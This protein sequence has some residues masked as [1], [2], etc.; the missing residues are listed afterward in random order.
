M[1]LDFTQTSLHLSNVIAAKGIKWNATRCKT[2]AVS[3]QYRPLC[4]SKNFGNML[5]YG[6]SSSF[7]PLVD[8]ENI[9][10]KQFALNNTWKM[11]RDEASSSDTN[12]RS[13]TPE[14]IL[15][16][17]IP[18]KWEIAT[19]FV[20][21]NGTRIFSIRPLLNR[22]IVKYNDEE[23]LWASIFLE[24]F[25]NLSF[26]LIFPHKS[27]SVVFESFLRECAC[28]MTPNS[29]LSRIPQV[30]RNRSMSFGRWLYCLIEAPIS[31]S[32]GF[33]RNRS[34]KWD[35]FGIYNGRIAYILGPIKLASFHNKPAH[36]HLSVNSRIFNCSLYFDKLSV[37]FLY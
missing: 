18:Q 23:S 10:P 32:K 17:A 12:T 5:R 1:G 21:L 4:I 37:L 24:S 15:H 14:A 36:F 27:L 33:P 29:L 34:S 9:H 31:S 7:G 22:H 30:T 3:N 25:S 28:S 20:S 2:V 16:S 26:E 19:N 8:A 35:A 13:S 6:D 11:P